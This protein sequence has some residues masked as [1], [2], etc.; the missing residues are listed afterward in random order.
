MLRLSLHPEVLTADRTIVAYPSGIESSDQ[1]N[2]FTAAFVIGIV[3]FAILRQHI[4]WM[5]VFRGKQENEFGLMRERERS[6]MAGRANTH[7]HW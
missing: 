5:S 6:Y 1:V 3:C 7:D 4:G 2:T